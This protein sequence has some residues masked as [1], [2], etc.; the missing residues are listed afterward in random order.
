M[1]GAIQV[2]RA[3]DLACGDVP[4][5]D[6]AVLAAGQIHPLAVR[7]ERHTQKSGVDVDPLD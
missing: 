2:D 5:P 3:N 4:D 6:V 1:K 7:R